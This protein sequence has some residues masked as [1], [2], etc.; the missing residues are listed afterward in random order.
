MST[1]FA[2][3]T[4]SSTFDHSMLITSY[5]ASAEIVIYPQLIIP[6]EKDDAIAK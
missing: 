2:T 4:R 3:Q 5:R 1:L 6:W